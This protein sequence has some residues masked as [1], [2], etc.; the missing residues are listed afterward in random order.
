LV[1]NSPAGAAPNTRRVLLGGAA[2]GAAVL[3]G[4]CG[5]H[6]H[7]PVVQTTPPELNDTDVGILNQLLD[8]EYKAV[9]AYTAGTPLLTGAAHDAAKQ[10]LVQELYHASKLYSMIKTARGTPVKQKPNYQL[11]S[12]RTHEDVLV[13]L[14][15]LEGAQI[16]GY[17]AAVPAV[18]LPSAR[19][20]LAAI[21]AN[22]A[23][24]D[25]ILR[26]ELGL[27]PL[28]GAFVLAGPQRAAR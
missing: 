25:V 6:A 19:S 21:L 27:E 1:V 8:L 11:G 3:L 18:S 23:Q 4:A 24:H 16:T 15:G 12:P 9:A 20:V 7:E 14:Q 17:L 13:L 22:D 10:F 28:T 5:S 2:A 26:A